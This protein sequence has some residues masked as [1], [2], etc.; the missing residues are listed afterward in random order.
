MA[1]QETATPLEHTAVVPSA[2][3][4]AG[5]WLCSPETASCTD[6]ALHQENAVLSTT[7]L[8]PVVPCSAAVW[9]LPG[10]IL[11]VF[12]KASTLNVK[13]SL[14]L[15]FGV[16]LEAA[17]WLFIVLSHG[18]SCVSAHAHSC[19]YLLPPLSCYAAHFYNHTVLISY[20]SGTTA[21]LEFSLQSHLQIDVAKKPLPSATNIPPCDFSLW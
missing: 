14:G 13:F 4:P 15:P 9:M 10:M 6:L 2:Q 17:K 12:T 19:S 21:H 3:H 20:I 5:L 11:L 8:M 18:S 16:C 7:A 1:Q